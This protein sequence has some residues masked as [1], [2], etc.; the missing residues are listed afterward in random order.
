VRELDLAAPAE[1]CAAAELA[2][3][4]TLRQCFPSLIG[5]ITE[6]RRKVGAPV[7]VAV[8]WETPDRAMKILSDLI[9]LGASQPT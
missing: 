3:G 8:R 4:S 7:D 5:I 1:L 6:L 2:E 9:W